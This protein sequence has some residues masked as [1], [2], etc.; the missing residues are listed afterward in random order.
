MSVP[1]STSRVSYT[2]TTTT[3]TLSVPFYFL[4]T[5]DL[6][7]IKQGTTPVTLAITTNY[8]VTGAGVE[9]GGSITLTG[10]GVSVSDV[11]TIKRNMSLTQPID[12]VLNDRLPSTTLERMSDRSTMQIQ[13]VSEIASR[14][15]RFEDGETTDG[16]LV[17][18]ARARKVLSFDENGAISFITPEGVLYTPGDSLAADSIASLKA[19]SV[20]G[21]TNNQAV[22]VL[23][24]YAAGDG[25]GGLFYY[26][27]ASATADNGG[28]VIQPTTGT[29]RWKRVYSDALNVRWFG[30]KGD[31]STNDTTAFTTVIALSLSLGKHI[32]IPSGTYTV[33]KLTITGLAGINIYGDGPST[34]IRFTNAGSS[35]DSDQVMQTGFYAA[36]ISGVVFCRMRV[37]GPSFGAS[38][39]LLNSFHCEFRNLTT[40][41]SRHGIAS[42]GAV[43]MQVYESN[44]ENCTGYGAISGIA[45]INLSSMVGFFDEGQTGEW[46]NDTIG[47][48]AFHVSGIGDALFGILDHGGKTPYDTREISD[49]TCTNW[50]YFYVYR[51]SASVRISNC[52]MEV[53]NY[54]IYCLKQDDNSGNLPG[55]SYAKS[56]FGGGFAYALEVSQTTFSGYTTAITCDGVLNSNIHNNVGAISGTF[57]S[58]AVSGISIR[59][60]QNSEITLTGV[61]T[62]V[63]TFNTISE[64]YD[65]LTPGQFGNSGF[66]IALNKKLS[67]ALPV[68]ATRIRLNG[69]INGLIK[70]R[71]CW[72]GRS[73]SPVY[74]I[75][76]RAFTRMDAGDAVKL[77]SSFLDTVNDSGSDFYGYTVSP[78]V[79]F[80]VGASY[81]DVVVTGYGAGGN[82]SKIVDIEIEGYTSTVH[83]GGYTLQAI[84]TPPTYLTL[85]S[86][87]NATNST[88][89][90]TRLNELLVIL[91]NRGE[92]T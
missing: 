76:A 55:T 81:V 87:A 88:D 48:T 18:T 44:T 31:G 66:T 21:L 19:I 41:K 37:E 11:I 59:S 60:Y 28:T 27:S 30:A 33:T 6:Q 9:A 92:I 20:S 24:Y 3:Q 16:T 77:V 51:N 78:A 10:V 85:P 86:V 46:W 70:V 35:G 68:A 50:P 61:L 38:F 47:I 40:T 90:V 56:S 14:S 2:L 57:I 22:S 65:I 64:I 79:A 5:T 13:Q 52:Y 4:A 54:P 23:G 49:C 12:L 8:T 69:K 82:D 34:V 45:L 32:Y 75:C 83:W 73:G 62:N 7:V 58:S 53:C 43:G 42:C 89:V 36:G 63:D 15:L 72:G 17:K 26:D 39:C 91:R 80:E 29:G 1:N 74:T 84:G 71:A 67:V 25:G